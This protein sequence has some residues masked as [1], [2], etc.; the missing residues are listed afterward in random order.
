MSRTSEFGHPFLNSNSGRQTF[1][2]KENNRLIKEGFR[3]FNTDESDTPF[4]SDRFSNL[5]IFF[6][7][8][9]KD[10]D[11]SMFEGLA[12]QYGMYYGPATGALV[13][14][15]PTLSFVVTVE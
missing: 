9:T 1:N 12:A 6:M 5:C 10:F 4:K 7:I 2:D 13:Q 8:D 11:K 3:K 14:N 15:E